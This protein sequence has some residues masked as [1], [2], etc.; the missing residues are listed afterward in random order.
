MHQQGSLVNKKS[1]QA[2]MKT[3]LPSSNIPTVP[4]SSQ[5][6]GGTILKH[7]QVALVMNTSNTPVPP[8]CKNTPKPDLII[9]NIHKQVQIN[10]DKIEVSITQRKAVPLYDQKQISGRIYTTK[11]NFG[12]I[13]T[14][15]PVPRYVQKL[16]AG[17]ICTTK[18]EVKGLKG[19]TTN[20]YI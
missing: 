7:Q 5:K 2:L 8:R 3:T 17:R 11:P 16:S 20:I 6:I 18:L 19:G 4:P 13:C 12:R 10:T 15:K 9:S 14:P 1:E